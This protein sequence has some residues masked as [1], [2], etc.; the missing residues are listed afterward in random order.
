MLQLTE[1][2]MTSQPELIAALPIDCGT[3]PSHKTHFDPK[4]CV[5]STDTQDKDDGLSHQVD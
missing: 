2:T 5:R 3:L 1:G 4:M